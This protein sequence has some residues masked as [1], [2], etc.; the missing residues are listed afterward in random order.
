M[1]EAAELIRR[2][3]RRDG[4]AVTQLVMRYE[5]T[6]RS[7]AARVAPRPDMA[8]DVAQDAFVQA[9]RSLDR[10]QEG[11]DFGLWVRGIVRNIAR[12]AWDRLYRDR[13]IAR[14]SLAEYVEKLAG[15]YDA[16][17]DEDVKNR[18]LDALR[19]CLERL[20]EKSMELVKLRYHL[21]MKCADIADRIDTSNA[22]VKMALLRVRNALRKC[23]RQNVRE[24]AGAA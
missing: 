8:E 4:D 2:A 10:F 21:G 18:Y 20:S 13:K 1:I 9:L 16:D 7:Y 6:I 14:D 17:E 11:A 22:A 5:V 12:Q 3:R 19:R 15:R 24:S 23:I